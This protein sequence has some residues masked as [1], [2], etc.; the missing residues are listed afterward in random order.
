MTAKCAYPSTHNGSEIE[1]MDY[2]APALE[3]SQVSF[4]CTPGL[5]LTGPNVAVC[6]GNGEWEPDP[7][8]TN[9]KSQRAKLIGD[10]EN[11]VGDYEK[12]VGDYEI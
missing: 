12:L 6:A 9:C 7:S 1:I 11:L 4:S 10:Y 5:V 3:G 2:V 8:Q